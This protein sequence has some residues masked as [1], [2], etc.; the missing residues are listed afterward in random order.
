MK[1]KFRP[2]KFPVI[3][4][5]DNDSG[6]TKGGIFA[7]A[8]K[9]LKSPVSF[10]TTDDFYYLCHNLYLIKTPELGATGES[11]MEDLSDAAVLAM[12]VN[13]K[14]F[15]PKD[16]KDTATEY[17]KMVFADKVVRVNYATINFS[18]FT[19]ILDRILAVMAHYKANKPSS[20]T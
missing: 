7:A 11:C 8:N 15:N 1:Y 17:G 19:V 5:V 12:K 3:I 2:L 14:S 20:A 4:L 6:A 13:G 9:L 10:T 18:K 16:D